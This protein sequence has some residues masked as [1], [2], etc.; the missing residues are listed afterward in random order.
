MIVADYFANL[1]I[2]PVPSNYNLFRPADT[3]GIGPI[4]WTFGIGDLGRNVSISKVI[5]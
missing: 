3:G 5:N 2:T 4:G 1:Q